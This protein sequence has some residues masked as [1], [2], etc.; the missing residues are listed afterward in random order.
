MARPNKQGLEYFPYDVTPDM[1]ME[2]LIND[3]GSKAIGVHTRLLQMIYATGYHVEWNEDILKL[4]SRQLNEDAE[5]IK[6]IVDKCIERGL[7]DKTIL[8]KFGLLTSK[9]IQ[10]QYLQICK[11]SKRKK[12]K[13]ISEISLVNNTELSGV[14]TEFVEIN[15]ELFGINTELSTQRKGKEKKEKKSE[16]IEREFSLPEGNVPDLQ[17][18]G[19]NDLFIKSEIEVKEQDFIDQCLAIWL[20]EYKKHR[21]DDYIIVNRGKDRDG[22]G[23]LISIIKKRHK[24]ISPELPTIEKEELLKQIQETFSIV[25]QI[26]DNYFKNNLTP[27]LLVSKFNEIKNY[28]RNGNGKRQPGITDEHLRK[29]IEEELNNSN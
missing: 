1:K 6:Q 13:F 14:I 4:F 11:D 21:S 7:F 23:K 27:T 3:F 5:T 19:S 2:M 16:S 28:I 18:N 8:E 12:I 22:I 9:E 29:I 10:T 24:E 25:L 15:S 26:D 20:D 17:Q